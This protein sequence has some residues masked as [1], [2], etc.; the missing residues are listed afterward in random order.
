MASLY[1]LKGNTLP[2]HICSGRIN[3]SIPV[4]GNIQVV[5]C[6]EHLKYA[7]VKICARVCKSICQVLAKR[8]ATHSNQTLCRGG[9][10]DSGVM[11]PS[12]SS[13]SAVSCRLRDSSSPSPGSQLHADERRNGCRDQCIQV[14]PT[15][16]SGRSC[17]FHVPFDIAPAAGCMQMTQES[18]LQGA[19]R[20]A[21][22]QTACG[23][24]FCRW[25]KSFFFSPSSQLQSQ[26]EVDQYTM[27]DCR[28]LTRS[29]LKSLLRHPA[30]VFGESESITY[31]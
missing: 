4:V 31:L 1:W 27:A 14:E 11:T 5:G 17:R 29:Q 6:A 20:R 16:C 22:G 9:P 26:S 3:A 10:P 23:A 28:S 30:T 15:E 21:R 7:V 12:L 13:C 2:A 18:M 25:Q 19:V 24:A 8:T